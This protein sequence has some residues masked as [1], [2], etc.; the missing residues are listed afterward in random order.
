MFMDGTI[1][2]ALSKNL[3]SGI[4]SFWQPHLSETLYAE[5]YQ[6]PP[7]AFGMEALFFRLFG[8]S[9]LIERF[10][11]L[12]TYVL[13]GALISILWIQIGKSKKQVWIPLLFWLANP[14]VLW[15]ISNNM[16]ENTLNIFMLLS[17]VFIFKTI[18]NNS[19]CWLLLAGFSLF[20][21]LLTKGLVALFPL[22]FFF[23][24]WISEKKIAIKELFLKTSFLIFF[25]LT[26]LL[27]LILFSPM[28]ENA[29]IQYF[30]KQILFSITQVQ[31]VSSRFFII[32]RLFNELLLDII[33]VGLFVFISVSK[34]IPLK[35]N[36][37]ENKKSIFLFLGLG[38]SAVL[39]ITI[40]LKQSG[41][42]ILP[43]FAF[44]AIAFALYVSPLFEKKRIQFPSKILKYSGPISLLVF[45][46]AFVFSLSF[47]N[48]T[49]R[50]QGMLHDVYSIIQ[51]LPQ[52]EHLAIPSSLSQ[53][54]PLQAYFARYSN[55]SLDD[56]SKNLT[57]YLTKKT[58]A[59][60]KNEYYKEVN[61]KLKEYK[62]YQLKNP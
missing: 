26:P 7:L 21:G 40:S 42:Y 43:A 20:L 47:K 62:L 55:I 46:L 45:I 12:G 33:L 52:N 22:S 11:S 2:A 39:P 9:F 17:V 30:N 10:Y 29:L 61:L 56:V 35:S 44:F 5:F 4:G 34:G 41:F 57:Y 32:Y 8:N 31:T 15:A 16:L 6:H 18:K 13:S 37:N 50:D 48:K 49:G 53:N 51:Y 28:A 19:F 36:Y 14:L 25:T 3:A 23:W 60:P 27:L 59:L 1:Y 58:S 24:Y 38:F 54:W